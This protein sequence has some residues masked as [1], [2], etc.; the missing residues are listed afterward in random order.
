MEGHALS[1]AKIEFYFRSLGLVGYTRHQCQFLL[2][3]QK[4]EIR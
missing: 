2:S 3:S 1:S 4:K